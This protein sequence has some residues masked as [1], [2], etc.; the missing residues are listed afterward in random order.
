MVD[1][2]HLVSRCSVLLSLL[3]CTTVVFA[4]G[5]I[6][7]E[8]SF[9]PPPIVPDPQTGG[10]TPQDLDPSAS[11]RA[12]LH[13][14][15]GQDV[16]I[17]AGPV[18]GSRNASW[19]DQVAGWYSPE[20]LPLFQWFG[21]AYANP[22]SEIA[23]VA[24]SM[25][26][27]VAVWKEGRSDYL[28][29]W[30][31][32]LVWSTWSASAK[33]GHDG[34][35]GS[36]SPGGW[37]YPS[38]SGPGPVAHPRSLG[39]AP[40]GN[41]A[42]LSRNPQHW[43]VFGRKDGR[44][45]VREW[46]NGVLGEWQDLPGIGGAPS[47][48]AAASD[49]AVISKDPNHMAVFFRDGRGQVWFTEWSGGVWRPQP[50]P[51]SSFSL[52]L[53][54]IGKTHQDATSASPAISSPGS[55]SADGHTS[56]FALDSE[57]SVASRNANH[58]AVFGVDAGNRLWVK[59]W[60][61][62]NRD[63][64]SDTQWRVLMT[65]VAIEHPSVAT[66]HSNHLGV[67]VRSTSGAPWYIEWSYASGWKAPTQ[68]WGTRTAPLTL[69]A[70]AIDAMSVFSVDA[71]SLWHKDWNEDEGWAHWAQIGGEDWENG[72][73]LTAV[74]RRM[75]DIMLFG[76]GWPLRDGFYQ[77]F[78][79]QD[80]EFVERAV[81]PT[82]KMQGYPRGQALAW[83][84][85][86]TLWVGAS[87]AAAETWQANVLGLNAGSAESLALPGH[88]WADR[89]NRVSLATGD[90]DFDGDD[91]AIV[92]TL[93]AAPTLSLSVLEFGVSPALTLTATTIDVPTS[94]PEQ[95]I[96]V[97]AALGDLD[98]DGREDEV[99]IAYRTSSSSESAE[100]LFYE[101]VTDTHR[102]AYRGQASVDVLW[103]DLEI[104]IG[105]VY[106]G[107]SAGE[108]LIVGSAVGSGRLEDYWSQGRIDVYSVTAGL[109]DWS[110]TR[111][112]RYEPVHSA[113]TAPV[114]DKQVHS[115]RS[116]L[117]TG[118]IDADGLEEIAYSFY[119]ALETVGYDRQGNRQVSS[120]ES[121][122]R[123]CRDSMA[124]GDLD[125]DGKAEIAMVGFY[126]DVGF[127]SVVK[128]MDEGR[129]KV[130]S[131]LPASIYDQ[132][133]PLVGDL[134]ND[135][136][137][138][139]LAGCKTFT[140]V[141]VIAVLNGPPRWY[142]GGAPVHGGMMRYAR[143]KEWEGSVEHGTTTNVGASL[144]VGFEVEI[145][146]PLIGTKIGEVRGSV[147]Q[148]FMASMGQTYGQQTSVG[149]ARGYIIEADSAGLVVYNGTDHTCFYYDVYAPAWPS[150]KSRAMYCRPTGR[151]FEDFKPLEDWHSASFKDAAGGSWVDVGHRSSLGTHTN[152]VTTYPSGLPIDPYVLKFEWGDDPIFVSS[153]ATGAYEWGISEMAGA[154]QASVLG[155]ETNTTLS[156]GATVGS[157]TMDTSLTT[158]F[159]WEESHSVSWTQDLEIG[160]GV[161]KFAGSY[162]CYEMVPYIYHAKAKT[163]AGATYP[164]IEV[165][166]YV[167]WVGE[168][169]KQ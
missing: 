54:L 115:Y 120:L 40:D 155:F 117:A 41:P 157:V 18:W 63:N 4:Q 21:P 55:R 101:Y 129:L 152:D 27:I 73:S 83:V 166:Y 36:T 66:R 20:R 44:I 12:P 71:N 32:E 93:A 97:S 140:E 70:T 154:T 102:L 123:E 7:E 163:V 45:V 38:T 99:A 92:A 29:S 161:E 127:G 118:D 80:R 24:T 69:A 77:H 151:T 147:T 14:P 91:E 143:G 130:Y 33:A 11:C 49:P 51:L 105:K 164:Y 132:W 56:L 110:I 59:E 61:N 35:P 34:P 167:P 144:S 145:N 138:S 137:R 62:L 119:G 64:W 108:Q 116:A 135:S 76:I 169:A 112:D 43:A 150:Q 125:R 25:E 100:I 146:V 48:P 160:G 82:A 88:P 78:S 136:L 106:D 13:G 74:A 159:G 1:H 134:D 72:Q 3:L 37:Y 23:A 87:Q 113:G 133:T 19:I 162:D 22:R 124:M 84:D 96:D 94:V 149:T 104:A 16:E 131:P 121:V 9:G 17:L 103:H 109:S 42:L 148:D 90:L 128:L 141:S 139:D 47:H 57:L 156:T 89:E 67:A 165:D 75:D 85:G 46:D 68:L 142:A 5:P 58:L 126:A 86:E 15:F 6:S 2:S 122:F 10:L 107:Q 39:L 95:A 79:A 153:G 168:C 31:G 158:G 98:G 26:E 60:T 111:L 65:D 8:S 50:V 30:E 28:G 52:Y 81:V 114:P 53:P